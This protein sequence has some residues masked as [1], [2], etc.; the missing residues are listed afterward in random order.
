MKSVKLQLQQTKCPQNLDSK[1]GDSDTSKRATGAK[2]LKDKML[3]DRAFSKE[4]LLILREEMRP[5]KPNLKSR[6]LSR[7]TL[8]AKAS[9]CSRS[10]SN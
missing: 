10:F 4:G 1:K 2:K 5:K 3:E 8:R 6:Q 7:S 9:S